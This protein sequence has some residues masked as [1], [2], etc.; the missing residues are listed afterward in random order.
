[1]WSARQRERR[2]AVWRAV[3]TKSKKRRDETHLLLELLKLTLR[4]RAIGVW[5][6]ESGAGERCERRRREGGEE[7][8]GGKRRKG[9]LSQSR[10]ALGTVRAS[11]GDSDGRGRERD[12]R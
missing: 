12:G 9:D 10:A 5:V 11:T 7:G 4:A 1:M 2:E 8:A 6:R 3:G